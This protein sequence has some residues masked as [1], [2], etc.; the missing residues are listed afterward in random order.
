MTKFHTSSEELLAEGLDVAL[1]ELL[2]EALLEALVDVDETAGASLDAHSA[3]VD[4]LE[5]SG[6]LVSG[7]SG[8]EEPLVHAARVSVRTTQ[9]ARCGARDAIM[10]AW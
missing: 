3:L 5:L 10:R 7:P 1:L 6:E 4:E 9:P 8:A 2:D